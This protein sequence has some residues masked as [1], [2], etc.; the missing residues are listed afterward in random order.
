MTD[1]R[2]M[3]LFLCLGAIGC[4]AGDV[5]VYAQA[6]AAGSSN[7]SG[8]TDLSGGGAG[9]N[10][11]AGSGAG[12]NSAGGGS[13]AGAPNDGSTPCEM[14]ADC[15]ATWFCSKTNCEDAL[16]SCAPRPTICDAN[17]IPVCGCDHITYWN[18]CIRQGYG[19]SADK[20]GECGANA[21]ACMTDADCG[22]P[23]VNCA[24]LLPAMANCSLK[25]PGTCWATPND[26]AAGVDIRHWLAC[27][28]PPQGSPVSCVS[29]CD[30]IQS[31]KTH[32]ETPR[33]TQCK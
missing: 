25:G 2:R 6:T 31:G 16:G 13:E 27:P 29:T 7:A 17:A 10:S 24:H 19:V 1:G 26:C 14:A 4:N 21:T 18:S 11:T 15:P 22:T 12:G 3:F 23:G 33:G 30:A 28:A 20:P 5:V 32:I 8:G 9:T